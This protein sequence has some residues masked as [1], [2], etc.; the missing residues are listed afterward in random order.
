MLASDAI[1]YARQVTDQENTAQFPDAS[2]LPVLSAV[3]QRVRRKVAVRVPTLYTKVVSF[4][5]TASTQDVTAAPLSLTDFGSTR[6]IRRLVNASTADYEPVGVAN[7]PN[8]DLVPFDQTYVFLE[9]GTV[10]EF[11]PSNQVVGQTF[12]LS[13]LSQPAVLAATSD[14]LDLPNNMLEAVGEFLAE[15]FR[16]RF[17]ESAEVHREAAEQA[18]SDALWDLTQRYGVQSDGISM[19]GSR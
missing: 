4:T 19:T 3:Y 8:P 13:Y 16:F 10:L 14:P 1:T 7:S 18:L 15:K 6:R 12:E 2:V 5:A 17:E 9:R 11:F